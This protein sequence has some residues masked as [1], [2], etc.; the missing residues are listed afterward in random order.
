MRDPYIGDSGPFKYVRCY[1]NSGMNGVLSWL[2]VSKTYR[3]DWDH[4]R[5][6]HK[7]VFAPRNGFYS[8]FVKSD[9][10]RGDGA[11]GYSMVST[12]KNNETLYSQRKFPKPRRPRSFCVD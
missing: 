11:G 5:R 7:F 2:E 9:V 12:V 3:I 1:S 4:D 6:I 8:Y 10:S